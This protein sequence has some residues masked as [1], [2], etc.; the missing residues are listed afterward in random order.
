VFDKLHLDE[1]EIEGLVGTKLSW[2]R[3]DQ[4]RASRVALYYNKTISIA[5][6]KAKLE[7]L[8]TWAVENTIRFYNAIA[9]R[10]DELL[11]AVQ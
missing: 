5:S 7:Q 8:S 11:R 6:D 3:I 4:K 9:T 10:A 1:A 2:E